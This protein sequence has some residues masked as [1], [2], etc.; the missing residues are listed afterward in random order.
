MKKTSKNGFTL[1]E[2]MIVMAIIA[3]LAVLGIAAISASRR[4][5]RD[6]QRRG[7]AKTFQLAL[8]AYFSANKSY[9][10]E[11]PDAASR[12]ASNLVQSGGALE[13]Y[14]T[15]DLVDPDSHGNLKT[16]DCFRYYYDKLPGGGYNLRVLMETPSG[17]PSEPGDAA[18]LN[19]ANTDV[20]GW[21]KYDLK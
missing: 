12:V 9:P 14:I 18:T 7:N 6:T 8:E 4:T 2:L 19:A 21:E 1:I 13:T 5:A 17:A 15:G 16:L 11:N 10:D 20:A 3:V